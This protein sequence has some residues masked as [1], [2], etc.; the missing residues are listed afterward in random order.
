MNKL[1]KLLDLFLVFFK[2]GAVTFG[3]GLAMLPILEKELVEKRK[4]CSKENLMDYF[5]IGQT[6][7]GIIAVNVATFSGYT[8]AKILGGIIATLG[9][10]TPSLIIITIIAVFLS[11]FSDIEWISKALQG[12]NIV[13]AAF[14]TRVFYNFRSVIFKS[15]ATALIFA[16]A[17]FAM[18]F[19]KLNT[20]FAVIGGIICGLV[21]YSISVAKE[22]KEQK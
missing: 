9:V 7:P 5:T 15:V 19:L 18:L 20:I 14:L 2:I 21:A 13:V 16:F 22:K 4:W 6:T 12:I 8:Q 10:V 11:G 3:G 1:R 17:L